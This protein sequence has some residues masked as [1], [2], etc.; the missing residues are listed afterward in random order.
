MRKEI[1]HSTDMAEQIRKGELAWVSAW[2]EVD[3]GN[4]D[5]AYMCFESMDDY[6]TWMSQK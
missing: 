6:N 5:I 2:S 3:D 4:G 1:I